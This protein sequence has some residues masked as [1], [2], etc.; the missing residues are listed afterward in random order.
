M[1]F[2]RSRLL[3]TSALA[4]LLSS[5][6]LLFFTG[7]TATA[8]LASHA[9]TPN[10]T[11]ATATGNMGDHVTGCVQ[12]TP[13][14]LT[15]FWTGYVHYSRADQYVQFQYAQ[16]DGTGPMT[17]E[18][19][20]CT[21]PNCTK[22][23]AL[24]PGEYTGWAT[25]VTGARGGPEIA[26]DLVVAASDPPLPQAVSAPI[27]GL[28][29]TPDGKGYWETGADGAVYAFGDAPKFGIAGWSPSQ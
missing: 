14:G 13:S 5:S 16:I 4:L 18:S 1:S 12:A 25:L 22:S 27:V 26:F 6:S 15:F 11:C 24:A 29:A 7:H 21:L 10:P 2:L 19:V 17:S 8:S 3:R 28:T 9:L 20:A 23:Y